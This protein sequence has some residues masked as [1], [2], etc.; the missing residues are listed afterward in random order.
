MSS[1]AIVPAAGKAERFGGAKLVASVGGETVLDRTL[2]ALLDGGVDQ[3]VVVSAPDAD[4]SPVRRLTDPRVRTV[5]NADPSRGMFSSIQ[6]GMGVIAG[7]PILVLPGD[8]PFVTSA[9]VRNI[10]QVSS[11]RQRIVIPTHGGKGGHPIAIPEA[12]RAR[13]LHALPTVTL[14]DALGGMLAL[15]YDMP[16]EDAGILRD[17]DVRGDLEHT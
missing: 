1:V 15:R 13:V 11:E 8:M 5:I 4:L 3:I 14:K 12:L 10:L 9:T 17:V 6:V 2:A 7:D 16:I